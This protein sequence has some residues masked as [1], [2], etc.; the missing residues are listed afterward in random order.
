M[1]CHNCGKEI[2]GGSRFCHYCGVALDGPEPASVPVPDSASGPAPTPAASARPV[3]KE[4]VFRGVL[5]ALLGVILMFAV[6]FSG[7]TMGIWIGIQGLCM[8]LAVFSGYRMLSKRLGIAGTVICAVVTVG[9]VIFTETLAWALCGVAEYGEHLLY[10]D[11]FSG[12][13]AQLMGLFRSLLAIGLADSFYSY[14][15]LAVVFALLGGALLAVPD[16]WTYYLHP[17]RQLKIPV[18]FL[19][20]TISL[21]AVVCCVAFV[22]G[23]NTDAPVRSHAYQ[24]V[25]GFIREYLGSL[26]E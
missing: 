4:R 22:T 17:D 3:Q 25:A 9:A 2:P 13:I 21:L 26:P 11:T 5:G 18:G 10:V 12:M 15:A 19:F 24:T 7:E 14:L 8:G 16:L 1:F 23:G 20:L 6:A